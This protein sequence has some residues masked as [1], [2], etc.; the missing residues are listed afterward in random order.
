[1]LNMVKWIRLFFLKKELIKQFGE[2]EKIFGEKCS[3]ITSK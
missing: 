1:M 2:Y 3:S